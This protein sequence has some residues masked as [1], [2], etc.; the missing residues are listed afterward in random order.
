MLPLQHDSDTEMDSGAIT[1]RQKYQYIYENGRDCDILTWRGG[2]QLP[3][4]L[5]TET[6][7]DRETARRRREELL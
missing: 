3:L 2:V 5:D 7:D 6:I 1:V 4:R